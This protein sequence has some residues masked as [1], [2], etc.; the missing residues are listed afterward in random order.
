MAQAAAA[1]KTDASSHLIADAA[2]QG[3][4]RSKPY[5]S[6]RGKGGNTAGSNAARNTGLAEAGTW[7]SDS[8]TAS[9]GLPMMGLVDPA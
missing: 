5:L 7:N 6:A 8:D 9:Q 4:R 3:G 1:T 2:Q